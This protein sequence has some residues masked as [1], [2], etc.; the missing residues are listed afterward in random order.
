[1]QPSL[2]LQS[3]PLARRP[4]LRAGVRR[5]QGR[6]PKLRGLPAPPRAPED[7]VQGTFSKQNVDRRGSEPPW[8]LRGSGLVLQVIREGTGLAGLV[9]WGW[10]CLRLLGAV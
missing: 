4:D 3:A 5:S 6:G 9:L 7:A 2:S 8:R 1:M 10:A